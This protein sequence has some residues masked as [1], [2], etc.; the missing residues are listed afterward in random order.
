DGGP[1]VLDQKAVDEMIRNFNAE[2][3]P[4]PVYYGH[5]DVNATNGEE[6]SAR[7]WVLGL[8]RVKDKLYALIDFNK[9]T[10]E[11]IKNNEWKYSS[12]FAMKSKDRNTGKSIG[13]RLYS[14]AL[15]NT[16]FILGLEPITL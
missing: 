6:P 8:S 4:L 9:E 10:R 11:K 15:T 1:L 7:G 5:A 2:E 14:I 3:N 12:I 16:P 13:H